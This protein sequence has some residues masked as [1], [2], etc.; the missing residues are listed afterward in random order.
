M[1]RRFNKALKLKV[2]KSYF[3]SCAVFLVHWLDSST[4]I[5]TVE[6]FSQHRKKKKSTRDSGRTVPVTDE[7]SC[8]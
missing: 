6:E 4:V 5:F 3:G 7:E 1:M 8:Q 2:I